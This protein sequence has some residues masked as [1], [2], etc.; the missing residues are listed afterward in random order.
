MDVLARLYAERLSQ[1]LGASFIVANRPGA[2]GIIAGQVVA[3]AAP[4]GYTL[5]VAN[6][7]H[8]ILGALNKN[9]PFDPAK[10]FAS[11]AMI[12]DTPSLVV[13]I[14]GLGVRTLKEFVD[15]AKANPG[16]IN[17]SSAGIG[18]ATHIAAAY[19]AYKAGIEMVHIPYKSGSEGI[20]DMLAG[21][22]EA[23][24]APAAFTLSLLKDENCWRLQCH[25]PQP[26]VSRS[27][28]PAPA[29]RT[30]ITS[31][32]PGTAFSRRQ[33]PRNQSLRRLIGRL[34]R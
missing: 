22:V 10:D 15:L 21:R 30:S 11:I 5:A 20:A 23:V 2:G 12:G 18:T 17:Y 8:A 13:I 19:F 29:R 27:K 16:K 31:T 7:G 24:F 14:P 32:L 4:D 6:S 9:L 1:R 28:C 3:A 26:C 33:K 25:P 34:Q